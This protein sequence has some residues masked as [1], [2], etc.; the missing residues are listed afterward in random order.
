M[1]TFLEVASHPLLGLLPRERVAAVRTGKSPFPPE[2][3]DLLS[4][5]GGTLVKHVRS[6]NAI[7][8][9][10]KRTAESILRDQLASMVVA[11]YDRLQ[12]LAAVT[13]GSRKAE[14]LLPALR[15]SAGFA[16]AA[17]VSAEPPAALAPAASNGAPGAVTGA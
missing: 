13:L 9:V 12:V 15:A 17:E 6:G 16:R 2:N 5:L 10:A 8:E 7:A 1:L 3:I 14:A 11:R 4:I